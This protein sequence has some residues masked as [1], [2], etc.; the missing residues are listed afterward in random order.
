MHPTSQKG[1][2]LHTIDTKVMFYLT[3]TGRTLS[4]LGFLQIYRKKRAQQQKFLGIFSRDDC[5]EK[6][7]A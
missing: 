3:L 4:C 1:V 2:F 6:I 7:Y 5:S